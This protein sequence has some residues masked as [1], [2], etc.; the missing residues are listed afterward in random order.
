MIYKRCY[1]K[2]MKNKVVFVIPTYNEKSSLPVLIKEI[3][4]LSF[5]DWQVVIVDDN[6]PDGTGKLADE[7]AKSY[8]IKVL[9][10]HQKSGLGT[11]YRVGFAE[12]LKYQPEYIVQMDADLSHETKYIKP[13]LAAVECYDLVIGSRYIKGGGTANWSLFR[14]FISSFANTVAR[15]LLRS[16]TK[17]MTSGFRAFKFY[18]L[19]QIYDHQTSSL[20]YNFQIEVTNMCERA[21]LRIKEVPITFV[22]RAEGKSKF[23]FKIIWESAWRIIF[24][25][26]KN[27]FIKK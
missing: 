24:L 1:N 21:G 4:D 16:K 11:A 22:E 14:K 26:V 20:G 23:D 27:V 13:L 19:K 17:D 25:S 2:V 10:R 7:L 12:A 15:I 5:S 18:T 3:G 6:S 9:H 8:P